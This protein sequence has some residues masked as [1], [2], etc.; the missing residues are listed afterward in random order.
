[1]KKL[2]LTLGAM[3][4]L[5]S[6]ALFAVENNVQEHLKTQEKLEKQEQQRSKKGNGNGKQQY[7]HQ[8]KHQ[9]KGTNPNR[10]R[11]GKG[12]GKR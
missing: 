9:Y 3:T 7:K 5:S 11:G 4:L 6:T 10:T 2:I 12:G 1:M 8:N